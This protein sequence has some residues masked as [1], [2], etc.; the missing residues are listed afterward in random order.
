MGVPLT[1]TDLVSYEFHNSYT[2][3]LQCHCDLGDLYLAYQIMETRLT[4]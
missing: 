4:H 1:V 3:K 2:V